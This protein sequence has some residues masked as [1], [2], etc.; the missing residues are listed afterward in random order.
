MSSEGLNPIAG[1]RSRTAAPCRPYNEQGK[2]S[3]FGLRRY[4]PVE[5]M[6]GGLI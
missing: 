5:S 2:K 3:K 4:P 6:R 1:R